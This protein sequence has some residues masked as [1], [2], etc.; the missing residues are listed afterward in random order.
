M[1]RSPHQSARAAVANLRSPNTG[2]RAFTLVE[3]LVVIG[4]IAVLISILLPTMS[5]AREQARRVNCLS[6]LRQIHLAVYEYAMAYQDVVPIGWRM[7]TFNPAK[8]FNSMFYSGTSKNFVLFGRLYVMGLMPAQQA[9]EVYFCPSE[10]DPKYMCGTAENPWPPAAPGKEATNVNA[11]YAMNSATQIYDDLTGKAAGAPPSYKMPR[12]AQF[13]DHALIADPVTTEAYVLKRHKDG[14][15]VL[16]GDG[17]ATWLARS[18]FVV[19]GQDQLK[20][21]TGIAAQWNSVMDTLWSLMDA[22]R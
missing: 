9:A 10:N 12:L 2:P 16:Y 4:I 20:I 15:N 21:P 18:A 14:I 13:K 8:Q 11:G 6:N 19:D 1:P 7:V 17:S 22:R 3:L 5:R